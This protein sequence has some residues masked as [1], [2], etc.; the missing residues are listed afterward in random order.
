[1]MLSPYVRHPMLSRALFCLL[2][3]FAVAGCKPTDT[4]PQS[5]MATGG[6]TEVLPPAAASAMPPAKT[7]LLLLDEAEA[8]ATAAG[9][10]ADNS[11]CFVCHINYEEELIASSHARRNIGCVNC[12][13]VSDAHIADESWGSGG[14]GT[15]PEI[16]YPRDKVKPACMACHPGEKLSK[17]QHELVL[18]PSDPRVCTDCHGNHRLP[19]RRCKWR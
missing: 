6:T 13:G 1:M 8:D 10:A 4:T 14:N 17:T 9:P 15:A 5:A 7:P 19:Q 12:H 11:R 18:A 2:M 16:M 3:V